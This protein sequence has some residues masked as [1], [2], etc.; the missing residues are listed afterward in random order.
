MNYH[1]KHA[2][3]NKNI[4]NPYGYGERMKMI[5]LKDKIITI[6]QFNLANP[7]IIPVTIYS[8]E[9]RELLSVGLKREWYTTAWDLLKR[10]KC[11]MN[12]VK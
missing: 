5:V 11:L 9:G 2:S 12:E 7:N 4:T 3:R 8:K 1:D 10:L 6:K